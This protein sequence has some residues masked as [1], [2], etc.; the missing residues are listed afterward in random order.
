[1]IATSPASHLMRFLFI[2][3]S[4]VL[5]FSNSSNRSFR[6]FCL[7]SGYWGSTSLSI[8]ISFCIISGLTEMLISYS[9]AATN[10]VYASSRIC[11]L[12]FSS[13]VFISS[14]CLLIEMN[15]LR[16]NL[17]IILVKP[18]LDCWLLML[19]LSNQAF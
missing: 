5:Y 11:K 16:V 17:L 10:L 18:F 7:P 19:R 6:R 2:R 12:C 3:Q 14:M 15:R 4:N 1:L 13:G 8:L 9:K